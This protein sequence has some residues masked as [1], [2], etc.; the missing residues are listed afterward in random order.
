M[1]MNYLGYRIM[2]TKID[3]ITDF[4]LANENDSWLPDAF[5][6]A[7][8]WTILY[9]PSVVDEYTENMEKLVLFQYRTYIR[10]LTGMCLVRKPI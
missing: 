2:E 10:R 5:L 4:V 1:T 8:S 9:S 7:K 6:F 3:S